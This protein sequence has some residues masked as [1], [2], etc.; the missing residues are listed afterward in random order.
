M[1]VVGLT[2]VVIG[3]IFLSMSV[4]YCVG[5]SK[6]RDH[7]FVLGVRCH[8]DIAAILRDLEYKS[9]ELEVKQ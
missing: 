5:Y 3:F 7:G 1:S 9:Q 6:G 2:L 8:H 4:G